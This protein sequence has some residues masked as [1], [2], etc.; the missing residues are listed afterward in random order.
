MGETGTS[1]WEWGMNDSVTEV[2]ERQRTGFYKL[3]PGPGQWHSPHI[4]V[5]TST[6]MEACDSVNLGGGQYWEGKPQS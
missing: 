1:N 6:A 4:E 3:W 2:T 5:V